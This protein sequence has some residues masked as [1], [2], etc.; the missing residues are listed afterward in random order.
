MDWRRGL[1]MKGKP[2]VSD[3]NAAI[4]LRTWG[5]EVMLWAGAGLVVSAVHVGAVAWA[6]SESPPPPPDASPPAAIMVEFAPEQVAQET[7]QDA[8]IAPDQPMVEQAESVPEDEPEPELEPEE[9]VEPEPEPVEEVTEETEEIAEPVEEE[10]ESFEE[11]VETRVEK[12]VVPI[13]PPKPK[14]PRRD[15]RQRKPQPQS[16]LSSPAPRT[17]APPKI[18]A[19]RADRTAAA[20]NA[21]G[22]NAPRISPASWQS[23]LLAH[24]ERRKRYPSRAKRR[25]EEGVA[26]VRFSIDANGN[27]LS[28]RLTRSSG[29]PDL[30]AEVVAMVTRASPVPA[31][32]PGIEGTITVPVRFKLR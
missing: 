12:V 9:P 11:M 3:R 6:L 15:V 21:R 16:Q 27:V 7:E 13:P 8:D 10:V 22:R 19:P 1:R 26:Y 18:E 32:P 29:F 25:R 17:T 5:G 23:R 31:P 28:A 4:G 20:Q 2:C 14:P 24:L 30:D